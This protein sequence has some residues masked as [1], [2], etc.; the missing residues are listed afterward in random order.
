MTS[1]FGVKQSYVVHDGDTL[2]NLNF[3]C[4]NFVCMCVW[5]FPQTC[6]SK[7]R[8]YSRLEQKLYVA[9]VCAMSGGVRVWGHMWQI[10]SIWTGDVNSQ[11]WWQLTRKG[12]QGPS[13]DG[14]PTTGLESCQFWS[15][16]WSIWCIFHWKFLL[17]AKT[18]VKEE[19]LMQLQGQGVVTHQRKF[20]TWIIIVMM[21]AIRLSYN[22]RTLHTKK[23]KKIVIWM[24]IAMMIVIRL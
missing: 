24:I 22:D 1:S 13:W 5:M 4:C 3:K 20:V 10:C 11:F 9:I 19:W 6:S 15:C 18:V 23:K 12:S 17:V 21:I 14:S 2:Q 16:G 8:I 7:R